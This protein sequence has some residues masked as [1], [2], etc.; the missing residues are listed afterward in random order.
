[1]SFDLGNKD[2][3]FFMSGGGGGGGGARKSEKNIEHTAELIVGKI[4]RARHVCKTNTLQ[5]FGKKYRA[6]PM[7]PD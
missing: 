5:K 7:R 1:M 4:Y 3:P 6:E 2:G